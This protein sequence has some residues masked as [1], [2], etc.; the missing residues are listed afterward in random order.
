M[1][2]D[3]DYG[4]LDAVK[5]I[6]ALALKEVVAGVFGERA[7]IAYRNEYGTERIPQRAFLRTAFDNHVDE[8]IDKYAESVAKDGNCCDNLQTIADNMAEKVK[9]SIKSGNWQPNA[10]STVRRKG[11]NTPLIDTG[12]MLDSVKGEVR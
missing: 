8:A 10:P 5:D 12:K 2:E 9:E 1:V 7:E 11:K 3:K 6:N 4:Y